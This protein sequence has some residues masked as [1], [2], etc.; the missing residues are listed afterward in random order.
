M[1]RLPTTD[2]VSPTTGK[3]PASPADVVRR[4]G[5]SADSMLGQPQPRPPRV[6][7]AAP[8]SA[9]QRTGKAAGASARRI[10]RGAG[11][12]LSRARR[13]PLCKCGRCKWCLDNV[14]WNRIFDEKFADPSY[15]DRLPV[16]SSST[17]TWAR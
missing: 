13:R 11:D 8:A 2:P 1:R 12:G 16:R 14:R 17:L 10:L 6:A 15:Y 5:D 3:F 4:V 7:M 9:Q